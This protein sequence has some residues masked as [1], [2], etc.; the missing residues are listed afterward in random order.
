MRVDTVTDFDYF[1][2][3]PGVTLEEV[4]RRLSHLPRHLGR[5]REHLSVAQHSFFVES[6]IE[7]FGGTRTQ[8]LAGLLHDA[9]EAFLGDIATPCQE[10]ICALNGGHDI[11][12]T[13]KDMLDRRVIPQLGGV[14]PLSHEDAFIVKAAD[15]VAL[16]QE[17]RSDFFDVKPFYAYNHRLAASHD[18]MLD[19][20]GGPMLM[21]GLSLDVMT[22][23][24]A[25]QRFLAKYRELTE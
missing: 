4:A 11:L 16:V 22:P 3:E 5:T 17:A 25:R 20:Y 14:Y 23:R 9:H 21:L 15:V 2:E 12:A 18:E 8:R 19:L 1:S 7:R 13:V 6:I 10:W 24:K